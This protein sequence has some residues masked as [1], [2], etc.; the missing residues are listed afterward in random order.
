MDYNP[1]IPRLLFSL[2]ISLVG[3][4]FVGRIER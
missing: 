1:L 2:T 3:I 4:Y